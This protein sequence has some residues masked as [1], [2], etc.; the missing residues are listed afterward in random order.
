MAQPSRGLRLSHWLA[1][2]RLELD[3]INEQ[4]IDEY[5]SSIADIDVHLSVVQAWT[6]PDR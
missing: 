5:Q 6:A 1:R 3:D 2:K 4:S